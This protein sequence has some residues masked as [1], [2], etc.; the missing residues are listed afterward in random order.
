MS[1]RVVLRQNFGKASA[2][3]STLSINLD[4][5]VIP[6]VY[7]VRLDVDGIPTKLWKMVKQKK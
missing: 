2:G 3:V 4:K 1:G 7:V 6:G 5:Q